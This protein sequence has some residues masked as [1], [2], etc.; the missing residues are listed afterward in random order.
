MMS[1][2][3]ITPEEGCISLPSVQMELPLK[4]FEKQTTFIE[5]ILRLNNIYGSPIILKFLSKKNFLV[6]L[7]FNEL[8]SN[9][10]Y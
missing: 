2:V 3:P 6:I 1:M 8:S 7:E 5:T 4:D 9:F 10:E